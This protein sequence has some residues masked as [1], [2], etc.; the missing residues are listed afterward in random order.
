MKFYVLKMSSDS[1]NDYDSGM[2]LSE[3]EGTLCP[4]CNIIQIIN[5]PNERTCNICKEKVCLKCV[6]V[7]EK[8]TSS[9][10]EC[11]NCF[12]KECQECNSDIT[13]QLE[14]YLKENELPLYIDDHSVILNCE[15][16]YKQY[17]KNEII[18]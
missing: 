5:N 6:A 1:E 2:D 3:E 13:K 15:E 4:V 16:C 12:N 10:G 18:K 14:E 9:S 11:I 17:Y 7:T 8:Y